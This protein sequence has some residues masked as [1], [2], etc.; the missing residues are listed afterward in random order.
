MLCT[1]KNK[2]KCLLFVFLL[3]Y[4]I[5]R[6]LR[7][8]LNGMVTADIL[9]FFLIL[10]NITVSYT[11]KYDIRSRVFLDALYQVEESFFYFY[12]PK[13]FLTAQVLLKESTGFCQIIFQHLI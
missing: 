9:T 3:Y 6:T 5:F 13:S 4:P 2:N 8:E 12:F 7:I 1:I 10:G 11:V